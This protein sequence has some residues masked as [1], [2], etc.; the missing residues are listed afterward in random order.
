MKSKKKNEIFNFSHFRQKPEK[1][2]KL[3][4]IT[5][6]YWKL[7]EITRI[8][9]FFSKVKTRPDSPLT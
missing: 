2:R 6:N 3:P 5:V 7:L 4:K 9:I 1:C 8:F